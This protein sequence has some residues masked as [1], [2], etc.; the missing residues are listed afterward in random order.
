[1]GSEMCIRDSYIRCTLSCRDPGNVW[2]FMKV[3]GKYDL[4]KFN[5]EFWGRLKRCLKEACKCDIIVQDRDMGS[6]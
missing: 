6:P 5:P 3:N 2:P 4:S 1:M